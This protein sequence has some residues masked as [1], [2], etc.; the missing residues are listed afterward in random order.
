MAVKEPEAAE[1]RRAGSAT[2]GGVT[3]PLCAAMPLATACQAGAVSA[4]PAGSMGTR[5]PFAVTVDTATNPS[6]VAAGDVTIF[7][8]TG[9]T[10]V[11]V[12]FFS[13]A[14]GATNP[15]SYLDLFEMLASNGF[16][17]VHVPYPLTP[18]GR[19]RA[20]ATSRSAS[21]RA[22]AP[23]ARALAQCGRSSRAA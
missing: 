18:P 13:H 11:P 7:R 15:G 23:S 1:P 3:L 22:W 12:L 10:N 17:V 2:D 5:G 4:L 8:P 21:T 20:R 6:P 9:Q 14:F 16:A 19:T